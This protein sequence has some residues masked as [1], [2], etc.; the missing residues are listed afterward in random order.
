MPFNICTEH[1][2]NCVCYT[3]SILHIGSCRIYSKTFT[4]I[5]TC[6]T[7]TYSICGMGLVSLIVT[8]MLS[9]PL[10][11]A[12]LNVSTPSVV[13]SAVTLKVIVVCCTGYKTTSQTYSAYISTRNSCNCVAVN[14]GCLEQR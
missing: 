1:T 10:S 7:C 5:Y 14:T 3:N 4:F 9:S 11:S 12:R 8:V 2:C 13:A 6:P